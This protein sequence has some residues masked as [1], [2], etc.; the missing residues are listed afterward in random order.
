MWDNVFFVCDPERVYKSDFAKWFDI[1]TI[2][3]V[4]VLII[5][6][7]R[8]VLAMK[9][10]SGTKKIQIQWIFGGILCFGFTALTTSFIL[11]FFGINEFIM[12]DS[13]ASLF[14]VGFSFNAVFVSIRH[15]REVFRMEKDHL[16][17][18]IELARRLQTSIL[19][20]LDQ[21]YSDFEITAKMISAE[22]IG[23]DYYDCLTFND[24]IW[25]AIGDVSGHGINAG[26]IAIMAETAFISSVQKEYDN[27]IDTL[28][29]INIA[30]CENI[31]NRLNNSHYMTFSLIK[32]EGDGN[33]IRVGGHTQYYIYRAKKKKVEVFSA[34][35]IPLGWIRT[36]KR[37]TF[38]DKIH[39]DSDDIMVLMT[40]GITESFNPKQEMLCETEPIDK[41]ILHSKNKD[42]IDLLRDEIL[43][44]AIDWCENKRKDDMTVMVIKQK[45]VKKVCIKN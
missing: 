6:I 10:F 15:E 17:Y 26:M 44:K 39:L 14:F 19:P 27:A 4:I 13:V 18:K 33:Y 25:L 37:G 20:K 38:E 28:D 23:G 7:V 42:N 16:N 41:L 30:L 9:K 32:Y 43:Q 1:Y 34:D 40:D 8:L 35:G 3:L 36:I 22:E 2:T 5:I 24:K 12:M 45:K 29:S 11:P 31:K 21:I